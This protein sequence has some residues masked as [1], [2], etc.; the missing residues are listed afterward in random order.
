MK[1]YAYRSR[2]ETKMNKILE[3]RARTVA[4]WPYTLKISKDRTVDGKEVYLASHPELIGCMA[5]GE[6]V[7]GAVESLEEVTYEYILSL[8]EDH[9]PI[10]VPLSKLITTKYA[11]LT[12]QGT[13]KGNKP[14]IDILADV[15]QPSV[16][17]DI[18]TVECVSCPSLLPT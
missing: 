18:S 15:A 4:E 3:K 12:I 17:E 10:P 8:L 7:K 11:H 1:F 16:R 6:T 14:F 2:K 13:V 9:V 5:Q